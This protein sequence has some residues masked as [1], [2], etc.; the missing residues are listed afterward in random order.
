MARAILIVDDDPIILKLLGRGLHGAGY[1]ID[2]AGGGPEGISHLDKR[3]YDA[4]VVD[5]G[6]PEI[7]GFGVMKHALQNRRAGAVI[8]VTGQS[9]VAVAVEAMRAGAA[10]FITKPVEPETILGALER[11]LGDP[12]QVGDRHEAL[13]AWRAEHAPEVV[14]EEPKILE[15]LSIVERVADT[16]CNVLITGES[17]T[18]KELVARAVHRASRRATAPFVA[19]N[20]AAIPKELMESEIFGHAKGAFTGATEKREGRFQV[21]DGGTLFLDEIGEMEM[22]LQG[23]FLRVIQEKEFTPI[24]ESRSR[25]ADVRIVA[26]TNQD[27]EA[28][29]RDG[30]FREDLFYRLNVLPID[31]PSLR[32]RPGDIPRLA[33][34]FV[35][36]ANQRHGRKVT[37]LDDEALTAFKS[38][39]WPG[40]VREMANLVERLVILK[41]E[42]AIGHPDLPASLLQPRQGG[43]F[44]DVQL[45]ED[46]LDI[47]EA[48]EKLEARLT[49]DA[50]RRSRGNK[51]KAAELLGLKR[52]TLIERLKRLNIT[53]SAFNA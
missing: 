35:A 3:H 24:G 47:K 9:S 26:A 20:C 14:G 53:D 37:G 33:A 39:T 44:E 38:H 27:L 21:A 11:V 10:D 40:N 46:G 45:P 19:V 49:V 6:M 36:Q 32:E 29:C 28:K 4:L 30:D 31:V 15:V 51:A 25:K 50:L 2:S 18:G 48:M 42:G 43:V 23:K 22:A 34:H 12:Q 5:L 1:D 41:A 13:R 52:T 7:D 8:V 16:D 17:G